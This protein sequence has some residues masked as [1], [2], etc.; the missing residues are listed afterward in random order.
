MAEDTLIFF[1][2]TPKEVTCF[3]MSEDIISAHFFAYS[4]IRTLAYLKKIMHPGSTQISPN[5]LFT[6]SFTII[7]S[8]PQIHAER[9]NL[10]IQ[11]SQLLRN[12]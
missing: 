12:G 4:S 2:A 6:E 11:M 5:F 7:F 10:K 1:K 8:I 3:I 9:C